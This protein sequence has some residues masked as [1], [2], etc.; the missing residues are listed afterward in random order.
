[1]LSRHFALVHYSWLGLVFI[2]YLVWEQASSESADSSSCLQAEPLVVAG[3]M[4]HGNPP[5]LS[6]TATKKYRPA[7]KRL[8]SPV[9]HNDTILALHCL[10]EHP[11]TQVQD[12]QPDLVHS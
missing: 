3:G 4:L 6:R 7:P 9:K 8:L 5:A 11:V 1:M 2:W 12:Q 10:T